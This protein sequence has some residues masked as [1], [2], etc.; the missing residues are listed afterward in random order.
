[1]GPDVCAMGAATAPEAEPCQFRKK[2]AQAP[3]PAS[4]GALLALPCKAPPLALPRSIPATRVGLSAF[5]RLAGKLRVTHPTLQLIF[6]LVRL[7]TSPVWLARN[8][9]AAV[10]TV[11]PLRHIEPLPPAPRFLPPA[12]SPRGDPICV[13]C[14]YV[15]LLLFLYTVR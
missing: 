12:R 13:L 10:A 3:A 15:T 4:A 5:P 6:F 14:L 2:R 7:R 8:V 11:V 9:S 1:V